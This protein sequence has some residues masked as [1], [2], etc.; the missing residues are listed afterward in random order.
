MEV[1]GSRPRMRSAL[2]DVKM[3]GFHGTPP[4]RKGRGY[5]VGLADLA[6]I[7]VAYFQGNN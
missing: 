7:P 4:E 3:A 1:A 5:G 6:V 2:R